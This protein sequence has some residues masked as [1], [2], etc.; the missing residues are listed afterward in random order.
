VRTDIDVK[1]STGK[2]KPLGS[3]KSLKLIEAVPVVVFGGNVTHR[4]K[5]CANE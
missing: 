4:A 3:T 5:H 2:R 1:R